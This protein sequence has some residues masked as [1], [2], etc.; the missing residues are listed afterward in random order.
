[1]LFGWCKQTCDILVTNLTSSS[2]ADSLF[3]LQGSRALRGQWSPWILRTV[4]VALGVK[5]IP[6]G[7]E[8]T[9]REGTWQGLP[10]LL[11]RVKDTF[12]T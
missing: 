7:A 9:L 8:W 6:V 12:R 10:F 4:G 3:I 2:W 5:F 1:M 11:V